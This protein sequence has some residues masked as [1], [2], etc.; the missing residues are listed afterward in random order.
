MLSARGPAPSD[1]AGIFAD[2][3]AA[4]FFHFGKAGRVQKQNFET[5]SQI[6]LAL[7]KHGQNTDEQKRLPL[8]RRSATPSP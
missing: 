8:T 3:P 4:A 1:A 6:Q 2:D 7:I 5:G